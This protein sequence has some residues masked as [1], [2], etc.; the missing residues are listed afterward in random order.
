MT[1][2]IIF[3]FLLI[4]CTKVSAQ[5]P[6]FDYRYYL[7]LGSTTDLNAA[8]KIAQSAAKKTG[9]KYKG[10]DLEVSGSSAS[11]PADT[12]KK[13]GQSYPCYFA[14]GRYEDGEYISV[15][16]SSE[17]EGFTEGL[18]IVIALNAARNDDDF[19]ASVKK[20]K[21]HYPKSYVKKQKIFMGCGY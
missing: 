10:C 20:I 18:F 17:Y 4:I 6:Q 8:K 7:I 14:R 21:A 15:E 5:D 13:Y 3:I 12:C 11:H 16:H 9:L 19:K 1:R 2:S